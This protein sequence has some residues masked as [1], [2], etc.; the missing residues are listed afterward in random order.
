MKTTWSSHALLSLALIAIDTKAHAHALDLDPMDSYPVDV[1][2]TSPS[3]GPVLSQ[4]FFNST[5]SMTLSDSNFLI[6]GNYD[7]TGNLDATA[8]FNN[9]TITPAINTG[10]KV[11]TDAIYATMEWQAGSSSNAA[12]I[13]ALTGN[14]SFNLVFKIKF[15][16]T[17]LGTDTCQTGAFTIA[18]TST[19]NTMPYTLLTGTNYTYASGY[20]EANSQ[21]FN[22]PDVSHSLCSAYA[23][24]ESSLSVGG[25][26]SVSAMDIYFGFPVYNLSGGKVSGS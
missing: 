12:V 10:A 4:F 25:A 26:S 23:V 8:G 1:L 17:W 19:G 18:M 24:L 13:D 7:S 15:T 9:V 22:I 21:G 2:V 14:V 5:Y 3:G 16:G 11:G 20:F 6:D